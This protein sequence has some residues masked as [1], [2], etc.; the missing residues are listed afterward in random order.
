[1]IAEELARG[2]HVLVLG[3]HA[4]GD[5]VQHDVDGEP[6]QPAPG[7]HLR[8]HR[9]QFLAPDGPVAR[10]IADFEV[11]P[12]QVEMAAAARAFAAASVTDFRAATGYGDAD[13]E[14]I[15]TAGG[16][17]PATIG[18]TKDGELMVPAISLHFL[19]P[20]LRSQSTK[21]REQEIDCGVILQ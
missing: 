17:A 20:G 16:G 8:R 9:A 10:R 12:Q 19:V 13:I 18:R 11:R 15:F 14:R 3:N 6:G 7:S 21:A 1:M 4:G 5:Q 2:E